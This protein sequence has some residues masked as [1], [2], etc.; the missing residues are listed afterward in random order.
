MT[1]GMPHQGDTNIKIEGNPYGPTLQAHNYWHTST[2]LKI[3]THKQAHC[4][5]RSK[6]MPACRCVACSPTKTF[7]IVSANTTIQLHVNTYAVHMPERQRASVCQ[8][9][10]SDFSRST[11]CVN[12]RPTWKRACVDQSPNQFS[13]Q[14]SEAMRTHTKN[15]VPFCKC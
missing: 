11:F 5:N 9:L 4:N 7:N 3:L 12:S 6:Q 14:L 2:T 13:T 1:H 15:T 10:T 8:R